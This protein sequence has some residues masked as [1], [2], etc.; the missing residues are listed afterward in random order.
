MIRGRDVR[1]KMMGAVL[2]CPAGTT[3]RGGGYGWRGGECLLARARSSVCV[4]VCGGSGGCEG[5]L[6]KEK[7]VEGAE[8]A[9]WGEVSK[10]G[11]VSKR[12]GKLTRGAQR[13]GIDCR[14]IGA[15]WTVDIHD[16]QARPK[17]AATTVLGEDNVSQA[18]WIGE[19]WGI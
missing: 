12:S 1:L 2:L 8:G 19:I 5:P 15:V 4:C 7:E 10:L 6:P 3:G 14:T 16:R 13:S 18:R 9:P 17:P 11:Q